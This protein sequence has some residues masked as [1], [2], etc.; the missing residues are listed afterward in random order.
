MESTGLLLI[1]NL[2]QIIMD[3]EGTSRAYYHTSFSVI[4]TLLHGYHT[5]FS[6]M[7]CAVGLACVGEDVHAYVHTSTNVEEKITL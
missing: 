2:K 6:R 5:K 4:M 7:N 3:F 1:Q